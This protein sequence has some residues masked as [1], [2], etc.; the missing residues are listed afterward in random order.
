MTVDPASTLKHGKSYDIGNGPF[1]WGATFE[2]G[3]GA[4]SVWF[5][6]ENSNPGA[7]DAL[8]NAE[9]TVLQFSGA[10]DYLDA[11]WRS[12]EGINLASGATAVI[13]LS[14]R[15]LAGGEDWLTLSWGEVSGHRANID[16]GIDVAPVP[17]PAGF[18]LLAA[19]LAGAGL[20]GRRKM[21]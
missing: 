16:L 12:G 21:S 1:H 3:D 5:R 7:V 17:V 8:G 13:S 9:G 14:T 19:A 18:G 11:A 15:L 2:D 20:I 10:F 6:F 4:G